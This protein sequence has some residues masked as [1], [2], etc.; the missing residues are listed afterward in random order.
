MRYGGYVAFPQYAQRH[1]VRN[2][3]GMPYRE[4]MAYDAARGL[5]ERDRGTK[6][7]PVALDALFGR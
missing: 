5:M 3:C 2:I 1:T 6:L 4:G 7:C